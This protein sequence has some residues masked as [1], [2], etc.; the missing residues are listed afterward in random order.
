MLYSFSYCLMNVRDGPETYIPTFRSSTKIGS[1]LGK[2]NTVDGE[3][4]LFGPSKSSP[5]GGTILV[6]VLSTV[7]AN[8]ELLCE[9]ASCT[10]SDIDVGIAETFL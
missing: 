9:S 1:P 10:R 8:D 5:P 4:H 2:K 6:S 3:K 7:D